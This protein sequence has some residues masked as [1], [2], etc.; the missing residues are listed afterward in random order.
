[1]KRVFISLLLL[2]LMPFAHAGFEEG[3]QYKTIQNAQPTANADKIEVLELFWYGCPH[4]YHLEP[5]LD[6]WLKN[7]PGDVDFVRLPAVLG[8]SWEL[9]ARAFYI[10][11]LLGISDKIH[12]PLFDRIHKEKK[13]V[14]NVRQLREFFEEQGVSAQ[15]FD[16]TY[17][18]FAVITKTN[19]AKQA[20]SQ[21]GIKGVPTM[22]VN[23]KYRTSASM[24][25]S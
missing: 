18:S 21:Y 9:H 15:E 25:G 22:V 12:K 1:M 6:A 11:E 24:A 16:D 13:P 20:A 10:A 4:C 2:L 7:K 3:V 23:G 14:R 8:P 19:R 5:E 17:K